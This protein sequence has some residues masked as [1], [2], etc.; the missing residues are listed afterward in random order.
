MPDLRKRNVLA[1]G[2]IYLLAIIVSNVLRFYVLSI[3]EIVRNIILAIVSSAT[4]CLMTETSRMD[5]DLLNYVR[6][7]FSIIRKRSVIT[8]AIFVAYSFIPLKYS[9]GV[10]FPYLLIEVCG[11]KLTM[12][13]SLLLLINNM[14][15]NNG[16]NIYIAAQLIMLILVSL[17][18]DIS[19]KFSKQCFLILT[20]VI[21]ITG[22]FQSYSIGTMPAYNDVLINIIMS[23]GY[24]AVCIF[25]STKKSQN[26]LL[27]N[28]ENEIYEDEK[29]NDSKDIV[30][31]NYYISDTYPL[32]NDI[33]KYD[34]SEY[35]HAR[36]LQLIASICAK[37]IKADDKLV[38]MAAFYYRLGVLQGEPILD[39]S[40]KIAYDY[41]FPEDVIKILEEYEGIYRIPKSKESAIIH[42]ANACLI[43]AEMLRSKRLN[44]DWNENMVIY[45]TL[46]ELSATGIYDDSG[47]SMNQFL[48]IRDIMVKVGLNV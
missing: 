10:I 9:M 14:I 17:V 12:T 13:I 42:M 29:R 6:N 2:L 28:V 19:D 37:E 25:I 43:K 7:D 20:L 35:N 41:C 34:I 26:S 11:L 24:A 33:R 1:I 4:I 5:K 27:T 38:E 8:A 32:V 30:D 18:A 39:N 31:Y 36:N 40:L 45:Q 48:T 46:N 15:I 23:L 3:S 21:F 44:S 22:L 47:I 16:S